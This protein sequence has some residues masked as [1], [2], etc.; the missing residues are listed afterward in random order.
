MMTI[1][2][3]RQH[4]CGKVTPNEFKYLLCKFGV[5][6]DQNTASELFNVID[7]DRSGTIG[8]I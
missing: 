8:K 1:K 6:I 2:E 5:Y 4:Q 7:A 3:L